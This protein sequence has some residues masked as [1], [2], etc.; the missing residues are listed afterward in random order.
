MRS[1]IIDVLTSKEEAA[2]EGGETRVQSVVANLNR[3]LNTRRGMLPHL[4]EYGLPDLTEIYRD[5]PESVVV[6]QQAIAK[7]VAR[8]E[9]RLR[10]VRVEPQPGD[11][12]AMELVFL[13]SGTLDDRHRV[14]FQ[15]TFSSND[16][17]HVHPLDR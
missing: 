16:P 5:I 6:L 11:P 3:L 13:V 15:T 10:R 12:Y 14:Q 17:T 7:A 1:S 2:P 9:P 4:P 8:Y